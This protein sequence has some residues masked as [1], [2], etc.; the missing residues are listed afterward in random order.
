MGDEAIEGERAVV[1]SWGEASYWAMMLK[2]A[3]ERRALLEAQ[4][5][6]DRLKERL[7]WVAKE[8]KDDQMGDEQQNLPRDDII[9]LS[10]D[11]EMLRLCKNGDFLVEGRK[12]TNDI[13]VYQALKQFLGFSILQKTAK[14]EGGEKRMIKMGW[15][16]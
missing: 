15:R 9:F 3:I 14:K 13:E 4:T 1:T 12:V 7:E 16:E 2:E 11:Q 6:V 10:G 5:D 8:E